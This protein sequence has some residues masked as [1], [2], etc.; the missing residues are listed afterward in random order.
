VLEDQGL[1]VMLC[2]GEKFDPI[3]HEAVMKVADDRFDD[4]VVCEEIR[5]GYTLNGRVLRPAMVK[6]AETPD[7]ADP[8]TENSDENKWRCNMQKS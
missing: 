6:V 1:K 5:K 3:K 4:G 8:E 7:D 2:V